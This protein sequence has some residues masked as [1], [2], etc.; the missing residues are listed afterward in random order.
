MSIYRT[1]NKGYPLFTV[2]YYDGD[3]KRCRHTF[4]N[5][6]R[7][8]EAAR[9][10]ASR[11][12]TGEREV[13]VL[14]GRELVV[15]QRAIKAVYPTGCDLDMAA[16]Q[17][18][19]AC[20]RLNGAPLSD[21]VD[22][23]ARQKQARIEP[24]TVKEVVEEL[25]K[26][27][28]EKGRSFLYLKDLRL[29]LDRIVKAF[30]RPLADITPA[31]IDAYLLALNVSARTRNNFR[32]VFG[33][34][35]RFGQARGYVPK[36][37]PGITT[38]EKSTQ[39]AGE[40]PV[41]KPEEMEQLLRGAKPDLIPALAIGAF[42]GIRPEEIKRLDWADIDLKQRHIEIKSSKAKTKTRRLVPVLR[43]LKAWLSPHVKPSG[44]LCPFANLGNQFA[45]L[46][47]RAKVT[48]KRNG[49]RHSFI[50]YYVAQTRNVPLVALECGN[51]PNIVHKNYLKH[52][53]QAEARRWFRI[54]PNG[55]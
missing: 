18:A 26:V 9:E 50:S 44:P 33:T 25:L 17:F 16:I 35:L 24:K 53:T 30:P 43:N 15:Y 5:Y 36:E 10:A 49:L 4:S 20:K 38:V 51:S 14:C 21:A 11:L 40:I 29:R 31:D 46:A 37:H 22:A 52:V 47:A 27:K 39:V 3:G 23:F 8:R 54:M 7:A 41:F 45:K 55:G 2:V 6:R 12:A 32:L 1:P 42:A 19:E 34:L 13:R 28:Q 48:W